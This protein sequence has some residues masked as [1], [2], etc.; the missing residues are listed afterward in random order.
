MLSIYCNSTIS[1]VKSHTSKYT[2]WNKTWESSCCW[3]KD[4]PIHAFN[5][6]LMVTVFFFFLK[7]W[8]SRRCNWLYWGLVRNMNR[9]NNRV[10]STE[11]TWSVWLL[12]LSAIQTE[13]TCN[14]AN[15]RFLKTLSF[16][17]QLFSESWSFKLKIEFVLRQ[18][19]WHYKNKTTVPL[20]FD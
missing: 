18:H 8:S 13:N 5:E 7:P 9:A 10:H 17:I 4:V 3:L 2:Q 19:S 1:E 6:M 15:T 11:Y 14:P 12:T 16:K 20:R